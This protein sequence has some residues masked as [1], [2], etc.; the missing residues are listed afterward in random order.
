[1]RRVSVR[2]HGSVARFPINNHMLN[3]VKNYRG[4]ERL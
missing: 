4:G 1:M 2:G 3:R